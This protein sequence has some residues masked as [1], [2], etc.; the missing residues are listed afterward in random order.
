M[1]KLWVVL[2]AMILAMAFAPPSF[3]FASFDRDLFYGLRSDPDVE[4]LQEFLT[5]QGVYSGPITGNFFSL[6]L[7]AVKKFQATNGILPSA[8]YF[9]P[10]TRL[11][12]NG[13]LAKE[14]SEQLSQGEQEVGSVALSENLSALQAE[15]K[16]NAVTL[17]Q[18]Q[19]QLLQQQ[20]DELAKSNTRHTL[21]SGV[22]TDS[23]GNIIYQP[24]PP[25][26]TT[27]IYQ[28]LPPPPATAS[29]PV[30][31]PLP[32]VTIASN[33]DI[34]GIGESATL[35]WD[36]KNSTRC[37]VSGGKWIGDRSISGSE[38]ITLSESGRFAFR[39]SCYNSTGDAGT[40]AEKIIEVKPD[41]SAILIKVDNILKPGD[42]I[43]ITLV[44][45]D[46]YYLPRFF[47]VSVLDKAGNYLP[48]AKVS[49]ST[50]IRGQGVSP[51]VKYTETSGGAAFEF[52]PELVA[53]E[54]AKTESVYFEVNS[55]V[56]SRQVQKQVDST[57]QRRTIYQTDANNN[58]YPVEIP[59]YPVGYNA[60]GIA[61]FSLSDADEPFYVYDMKFETD[62]NLGQLN[63]PS[64][65][66]TMMAQASPSGLSAP[67]IYQSS[68][69][70]STYPNYSSTVYTVQIGQV[71]SSMVGRHT[72]TI[73]E[74]EVIG[75]NSG[76]TRYMQGL[77]MTFTFV[78]KDIP[79][80]EVIPIKTTHTHCM[81]GG[82]PCG[83]NPGVIGSFKI[84]MSP[85]SSIRVSCNNIRMVGD[86]DKYT[87][88]LYADFA[89]KRFSQCPSSSSGEVNT[90]NDGVSTMQFDLWVQDLTPPSNRMEFRIEGMSVRD[91]PTG[92][93]RTVTN[94]PIFE[95]NIVGPLN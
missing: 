66:A 17:L 7:A 34:I 45:N 49:M 9:G 15:P 2:C 44:R 36:S 67:Y 25:Q 85:N 21:P 32:S 14:I 29:A 86:S 83:A 73:K 19:I 4:E 87:A 42:G 10:K 20:I 43:P 82:Y 69:F 48:Y 3:V 77:P 8:G 62:I 22:V 47:N 95:L 24:P 50:S 12:V 75:K 56:T 33:K 57:I 55:M 71:T 41:Q 72:L 18:K 6:T 91:L 80:P 53:S 81:T 16:D 40:Q 30:P 63:I 52:P 27:I 35:T 23:Q 51:V 93:V 90:G 58:S 37:S 88:Y 92:I 26:T 59:E 60:A 46:V 38:I 78:I 65:A 89:N 61:A 84:R 5:S 76:M 79:N 28:A 70:Q 31:P 94:P 68:P 39:I 1:K 64:N 54:L 13:T 11:Y 74:I